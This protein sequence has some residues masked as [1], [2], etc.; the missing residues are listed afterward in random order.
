MLETSECGR[1]AAAEWV[2]GHCRVCC[3]PAA[4]GGT[5]AGSWRELHCP[6]FLHPSNCYTW[7]R[8]PGLATSAPLAP[9]PPRRLRCLFLSA[10]AACKEAHGL[11]FE[12]AQLGAVLQK[13]NR[14]ALSVSWWLAA[15]RCRLR[16]ALL[17]M[18]HWPW[19]PYAMTVGQDGH[20]GGTACCCFSRLF[21]N[22]QM[23]RIGVLHQQFRAWCAGCAVHRDGR[24]TAAGPPACCQRP[25]QGVAL[26]LCLRCRPAYARCTALPLPLPALRM[27]S[28]AGAAA[29]VEVDCGPAV[30]GDAA[31]GTY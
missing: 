19:C 10:A 16:A 15:Y 7:L 8:M 29:G 20:R 13:Q 2:G 30:L 23:Q 25:W 21:L 1:A 14:C 22:P 5:H 27:Q 6:A 11:P 26:P 4:D 12:S 28:V 9:P 24:R 18:S 3:L 31:G 17:L